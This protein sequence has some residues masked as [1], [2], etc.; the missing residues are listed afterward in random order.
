MRKIAIAALALAAM[1]GCTKEEST[2]IE[3]SSEVKFASAEIDTRVSADGTTWDAAED[4]GVS[5]YNIGT[6]EE[7]DGVGNVHY[8]STNTDS[9]ATAVNF[10]VAAGASSLLY[11]NTGDV[12][13]YA[14]YPYFDGTLTNGVERTLNI[15]DQSENVDFMVAS[16]ANAVNRYSGEIVLAFTHKMAKITFIITAND[17]VDN[18]GDLS[19]V[20]AVGF[21]TEG[22]YSILTGEVVAGTLSGET[23]SFGLVIGDYV[24][25]TQSAAEYITATAIVHPETIAAV[26]TMTFTIDGGTAEERNFEILIPANS[27]FEVGKN[28]TY[29]VALGN[30]EPTFASGSTLTGWQEVTEP[31][32]YSTEQ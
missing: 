1:V 8:V 32:L 3:A 13:F 14:Y 4:I 20:S 10:A 16:T 15:V 28:H 30:D 12:K 22:R 26:A 2:S 27:E 23:T 5:M 18:I 17:N 19:A 9:G 25:A 7:L 21:S 11:P 31:E 24:A 29:N 6:T